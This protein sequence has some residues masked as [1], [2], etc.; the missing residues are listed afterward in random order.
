MFLQINDLTRL[1][2]G[3]YEIQQS[4]YLQSFKYISYPLVYVSVCF[5]PLLNFV[6]KVFSEVD[7]HFVLLEFVVVLL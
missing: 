5:S 3:I 2:I 1:G 7:I 4:W 6:L